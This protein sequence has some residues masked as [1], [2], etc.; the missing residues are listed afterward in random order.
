MHTQRNPYPNGGVLLTILLTLLLA[1]AMWGLSSAVSKNM[2][3]NTNST[4]GTGQTIY[5]VAP[6]SVAVPQAEPTAVIIT[7][8]IASPVP[9]EPTIPASGTAEFL[10]WCL[11]QHAATDAYP[12]T[13]EQELIEQGFIR[14]PH[15]SQEPT[16][17]SAAV[18]PAW[19]TESFSAQ[20][21]QDCAQAAVDGRRSHPECKD[22]LNE[23]GSGR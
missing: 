6:T 10:L 20:F 11:N 13:C 14:N 4:E 5:E 15:Q 3:S 18:D 1:A 7:E 12:G 9:V 2:D 21:V 17:K 22:A 8:P 23:L 19:Q 16:G